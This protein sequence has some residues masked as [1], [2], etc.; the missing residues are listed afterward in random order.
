MDGTRLRVADQVAAASDLRRGGDYG[1][2]GD[3]LR[4]ALDDAAGDLPLV[5]WVSNELGVLGK[6]TGA[7]GEAE[8]HYRRALRIYRD[9]YGPDH[10]TVATAYHNLVGLAHARGD[11]EA[12]EPLAR[13]AAEIRT[14]LHGPDDPRVAADIAAWA[15]L[16][17]GCGRVD[18]AEARLRRT[19]TI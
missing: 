11:H 8:D 14:R 3:L 6:Y 13:R 17:D 15:A 2:A 12:G 10:D 1:R 4:L 7:F 5:A 19:L 9:L 16:L 18:E